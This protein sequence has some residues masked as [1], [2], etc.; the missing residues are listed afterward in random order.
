MNKRKKDRSYEVHI[1]GKP[2]ATLYWAPNIKDALNQF[3]R[4]KTY[5][6]NDGTYLIVVNRSKRAYT[7]IKKT[8]TY[9]RTSVEIE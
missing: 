3:M 2:W 8:K 4:D 1:V 6:F 9:T 7:V 5:H